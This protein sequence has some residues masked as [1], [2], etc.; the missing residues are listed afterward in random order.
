MGSPRE[1]G[2]KVCIPRRGT[3][4]TPPVALLPE[5]PL[6]CSDRQKP[7]VGKWFHR[8]M[9]LNAG[10][11]RARHNRGQS[12][13]TRIRTSPSMPTTRF[14]LARLDQVLTR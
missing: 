7:P 12:S 14:T 13:E 1:A 11:L 2:P 9:H 6:G 10:L 8:P 5:Q 3:I 4:R